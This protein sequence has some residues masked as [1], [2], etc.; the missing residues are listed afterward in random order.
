[1]CAR[2]RGTDEAQPDGVEL[3]RR[4]LRRRIPGPETVAVARD[5]REAGDL[6]V[7]DQ[8]VDFGALCVGA[9]VIARAERRIRASGPGFLGPA[10][11][12]IFAGRRANRVCLANWPRSSTSPSSC[13]AVP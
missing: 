4:Q 3:A 13:E 2:E 1:A 5:D 12:K 7:A 8:V 9:P 10:G 11:R 6:R